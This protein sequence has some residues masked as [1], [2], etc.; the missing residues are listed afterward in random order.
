MWKVDY[1]DQL[2]PGKMQC[3]NISGTSTTCN[4]YNY[5]Y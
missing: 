4:H 3:S 1:N 2:V 5:F